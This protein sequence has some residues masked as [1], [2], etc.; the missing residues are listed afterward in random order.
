[1]TRKKLAIH[2][3]R[4]TVWAPF[5]TPWTRLKRAAVLSAD[6]MKMAPRIARGKTTIGDGSGK[7]HELFFVFHSGTGVEQKIDWVCEGLREP[8]ACAVEPAWLQRC[9]LLGDIYPAEAARRPNFE[10]RCRD[11]AVPMGG[12]G[13]MN[14]PEVTSTTELDKAV[15]PNNDGDLVLSL[16]LQ[17]ART[18]RSNEALLETVVPPGFTNEN[19]AE[20]AL[21]ALAD[22]IKRRTR[23][24]EGHF[25]FLC[26]NLRDSVLKERILAITSTS[27]KKLTIAPL[28]AVGQHTEILL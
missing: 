13:M 21:W 9:G 28:I 15:T 5:P 20:G 8:L 12:P 24:Q 19:C 14:Y 16:I 25:L 2:G 1:M 7:S 26:L 27:M 3:G 22:A 11:I 23:A 6:V 4:R 10:K 18:S 17:F